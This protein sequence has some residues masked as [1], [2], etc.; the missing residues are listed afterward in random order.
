MSATLVDLLTAIDSRASAL[1]LIEPGPTR[2]HLEQIMRAGV[3][4][5]DHG[6]LRPWRFLVVR[7][8]ARAQLGEVFM[9][10]YQRRNPE[11]QLAQLERERAKPMRAPLIIVVAAHVIP[12]SNIPVIEQ[13][14][15]AAA[16][17]QNIMLCTFAM[18]YG[19]SWKTGDSAYDDTV[20]AAL[21]LRTQDAIVGFMYL[22]TNA[23]PP[24]APIDVDIDALVST[25]T[26]S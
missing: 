7:E 22:G 13:I 3:R 5:P 4:A 6:R 26:S 12:E 16:A 18:G 1:K 20:K 25:W 19:C 10:A 14:L 24:S 8:A 17:A 9:T 23:T 21:G 15:S 2:V 11:A